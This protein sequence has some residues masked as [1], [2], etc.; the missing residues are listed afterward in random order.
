MILKLNCTCAI[1]A[2]IHKE[3]NFCWWKK[4]VK[5]IPQIINIR[6]LKNRTTMKVKKKTS[7]EEEIAHPTKSLPQNYLHQ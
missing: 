1:L 2:L 3:A 7:Q 4:N 5:K 6:M